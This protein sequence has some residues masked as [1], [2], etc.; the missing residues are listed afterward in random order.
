MM[1][2]P[3]NGWVL[4]TAVV[5]SSVT[6]MVPAAEPVPDTAPTRLLSRAIEGIQPLFAGRDLKRGAVTSAFTEVVSTARLSTVAV[7]CDGNHAALGTV[8]VSDGYILTKSSVLAGE[9]KCR[10]RDKGEKQRDYPATLIAKDRGN[11]IALL[12]IDARNLRPIRWSTAKP[13][14]GAWLASSGLGER[15]RA[16]GVLSG[17]ARRIDGPRGGLGVGLAAD[18]GDGARI[19]FVHKDSAA[20]KIGLAEGDVVLSVDGQLIPDADALVRT[21]KRYQPGERVKLVIRRGNEIIKEN[22][23]LSNLE[24]IMQPDEQADIMDSLG[25][26]L[27]KRRSGFPL[28]LQHDTDLRPQDC[29]GPL[30]DLNGRAVG[31]NIARTS[32]VAT[33]AI[34]AETLLAL[35]PQLMA[36][37]E[38]SVGLQTTSTAE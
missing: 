29:G 7:L 8:V 6:S 5:I 20:A 4:F 2:A 11:D 15:P 34:P 19:D 31:I 28:A 14:V 22:A 36:Q 18:T 38:A 30:V 12:K 17:A 25:G 1:K 3:K 32:R 21:M 33:Y 26:P 27:S 37:R 13:T 10:I 9:I 16:V 35:I 23:T 24:R